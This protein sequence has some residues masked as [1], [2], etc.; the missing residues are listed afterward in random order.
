[1]SCE[2]EK[3]MGDVEVS[4]VAGSCPCR[5]MQVIFSMLKATKGL[6]EDTFLLILARVRL[7]PLQMDADDCL[8]FIQTGLFKFEVDSGT[9]TPRKELR[10]YCIFSNGLVS[11]LF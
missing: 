6:D 8:H 10:Y 1:M 5:H 2:I 9:I 3:K 4:M 7:L 11:F